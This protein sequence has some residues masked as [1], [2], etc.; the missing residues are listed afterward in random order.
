MEGATTPSGRDSSQFVHFYARERAW[1]KARRWLVLDPFGIA[2]RHWASPGASTFF[3]SFPLFLVLGPLEGPLGPSQAEGEARARGAGNFLPCSGPLKHGGP[4]PLS[5]S[6]HRPDRLFL[7]RVACPAGGSVGSPCA[8]PGTI[9][10]PGGHSAGYPAVF[11]PRA[12]RR[13]GGL[14]VSDGLPG[15]R[16]SVSDC[17]GVPASCLSS[18]V[19]KS[20]GRGCHFVFPRPPE[21]F[22]RYCICRGG[23]SSETILSSAS[24]FPVLILMGCCRFWVHCK[25]L[26]EAGP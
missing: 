4:A 22:T 8:P 3:G 6:R 15:Q 18:S 24:R 17:R 9:A 12:T 11:A 21:E 20:D 2:V 19:G 10:I 13:I 7:R 16:R 23:I 26:V 25:V 14:S 5:R 1:F